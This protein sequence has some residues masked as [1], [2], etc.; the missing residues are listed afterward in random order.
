MAKGNE[1]QVITTTGETGKYFHIL[2]NMADDQLDPFEYR[3]YGHYV[4][5]ARPGTSLREG[6][7]TSARITQMSAAKVRAARAELAELG[8]ILVEAPTPDE[9][10]AGIGARVTVLDRMTENVMRYSYP[11]VDLK[12]IPSKSEGGQALP[13]SKSIGDPPSNMST[14]EE[15]KEL[16]EKNKVKQYSHMGEGTSVFEEYVEGND[17][18][19]LEEM[20]DD[21]TQAIR[22]TSY[23]FK[24]G[25]G[26][27][28][29][30]EP[31]L[32]GRAAK[33]KRADYNIDP[34]LKPIEIVA[35]GMWYART[36]EMSAKPSQDAERI[37][38]LVT[39]FQ[40]WLADN[41]HVL[42]RARLKL[43][44]L[45]GIQ[46]PAPPEEAASQEEIDAAFAEIDEWR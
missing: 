12:G 18:A 21:Y 30:L 20:P 31:Q 24:V 28:R 26:M 11:P 22:A 9:I 42:A 3:L 40:D 43:R 39:D 19:G 14:Y 38:E 41:P 36:Y 27:A 33:G 10:K 34:G 2:L 15:L 37:N 8:Y 1:T 25:D 45:F 5:C 4:R 35:F 46:E 13:P 17:F 7:E 29:A 16:E 44:Q 23:A 6:V 32:R